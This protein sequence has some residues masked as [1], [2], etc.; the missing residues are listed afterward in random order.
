MSP[1]NNLNLNS[2][3]EAAAEI[4][5]KEGIEALTMAVLAKRLNVRT[6]SLYNHINGLNDLRKELA[7]Y[8]IESL[9]EH[10]MHAAV[11]RAGDEAVAAIAKAYVEFV[12]SHPG[13]YEATIFI[14]DPS[15]ID[16]QKAGEKVVELC[17][18]V[19]RAYDLKD[20]EALHATRGLRSILHGFASL[21]QKGG[22]GMPLDHD[23]SLEL[24]INAYISGVHTL[25]NEK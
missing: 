13:I 2:I 7:I 3:L 15:D 4:A 17:V 24:M 21:E 16:F 20:E 12:R 1:R 25:K 10:L 6:P 19:L 22:F 18:R 23:K 5:D 14:P 9:Y 11:G 8:G